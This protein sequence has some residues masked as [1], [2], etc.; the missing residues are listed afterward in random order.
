[1]FTALPLNRLARISL[2]VLGPERTRTPP[3]ALATTAGPADRVPPVVVPSEPLPDEL[4]W[5][6]LP[7]QRTVQAAFWPPRWP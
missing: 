5:A 4:G 7:S 3:S 1:M 2:E 6:A